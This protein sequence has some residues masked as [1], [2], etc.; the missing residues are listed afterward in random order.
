M[1]RISLL[2]LLPLIFVGS[3]FAQTGFRAT[4]AE[5]SKQLIIETKTSGQIGT[6]LLRLLSDKTRY[7]IY[8]ISIDDPEKPAST[9]LNFDD[10][11]DGPIFCNSGTGFCLV[12]LKDAIPVGNYVIKVNGLSAFASNTSD[13]VPLFF[14]LKP[15][16]PI[17]G[18]GP[19]STTATIVSSIDGHRNKIRVQSKADITA[20][21]PL[22]V[23]D[24]TLQ[25]SA[26]NTRVI[27]SNI[28]IPANVED[29]QNPGK[30]APGATTGKEFT[31]LLN[32]SLAEA[33][34]H[35]LS[36]A[37]GINDSSGNPVKTEG[38]VEIPGLPKAPDAL[39]F[40]LKLS[41]EAA[42][43][44]KPFFNLSS[45]Y[46]A[47]D[48]IPIGHCFLSVNSLPCYWQPQISLD[49]GLG[50]TK[51]KNAIV[52]DL[53]FRSIIYNTHLATF[54]PN[55]PVFNV[56][57]GETAIPTYYGWKHTPLHRGDVYFFFGPKFESDRK[58]GRINTLGSLRLDFRMHRL[59]GS[60]AQKRSLLSGGA[61]F[62]LTKQQLSQV[63]VTSGFSLVP[64]IGVDFGRKVTA[65]VLT[66]NNLRQV[67]PP[68]PIFRA[69]GGFKGVLEFQ[70][71][72]LP[73]SFNL[74]EKL[75]YLAERE[76]VGAV[77][78]NRI[79]IKRIKGFQPRGVLSF[80]AF[81]NQARRYSFNVTYENGRSAPNFEYLNKISAG[82][83]V[84]Y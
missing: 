79:D 54:S 81:L 56:G 3:V 69:F 80:D 49:L 41:S 25:I 17:P 10:V 43:H 31:L 11:A 36:I 55:D 47:Q 66:K 70:M 45:K 32:N 76:T 68:N 28:P 18:A 84:A 71:F 1:R 22:N 82:F 27:P 33:R 61:P 72:T 9:L 40:E 21:T 38:S 6:D 67:I 63:E 50:D 51:S 24:T 34:T 60:I 48:Q 8:R 23:V 65:E 5:G 44:Q 73:M 52:I 15:P 29:P 74:D 53:P 7:S 58:F 13:S 83:R 37:T 20:T 12:N 16:K 62:G 42:H 64:T 4:V 57:N 75:F 78:G 46:D 2:V 35:T 19:P 26:D 14:G 30:P 77:I 39:N 59:L